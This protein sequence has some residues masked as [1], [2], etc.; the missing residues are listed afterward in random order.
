MNRPATPSAPEAPARRFG[1]EITGAIAQG[2]TAEDLTLRLTLMDASKVKRDPSVA[3]GDISFSPAGMRF[4][5]VRVIEGGV[6]SSELVAGYVEPEVE[7]PAAPVPKT[8]KKAAA[9][10]KTAAKA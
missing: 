3:L 2:H 7:A 10:P 8:R 6:R 1:R 4:L 9:K 5:G